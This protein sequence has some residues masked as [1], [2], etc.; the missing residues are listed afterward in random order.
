MAYYATW[1]KPK[2]RKRLDQE[3]IGLI[4]ES[5]VNELLKQDYVT[6]EGAEYFTSHLLNKDQPAR[7]TET[8]L[9]ELPEGHGVKVFTKITSEKTTV[10]A[11]LYYDPHNWVPQIPEFA[12]QVNHGK[13]ASMNHLIYEDRFFADLLKRINL[14]LN[15]TPN[16]MVLGE[17]YGAI[18]LAYGVLDVIIN[19][20]D[21]FSIAFAKAIVQL[22]KKSTR[23]LL[24]HVNLELVIG[25]FLRTRF[26]GST[27]LEK[28]VARINK[29][30]PMIQVMSGSIHLVTATGTGEQWTSFLD[31]G[32][33]LFEK[34]IIEMLKTKETFVTELGEVMEEI[35]IN[36]ESHDP[37]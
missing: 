21:V 30:E 12:W 31:I 22:L 17:H 27:G 28:L 20:L 16:Y 14:L 7:R 33:K 3:E 19:D 1:K 37:R 23:E 10:D 18:E 4:Y 32:A 29:I 8:P 9:S 15:P 5:I 35:H 24:R 13:W 6:I 25:E 34:S 2:T 26:D 36:S 11:I